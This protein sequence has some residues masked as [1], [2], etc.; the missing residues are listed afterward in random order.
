MQHNSN[1]HESLWE[2]D[3]KELW[4]LQV[5]EI[6]NNL[7]IPG[8][9]VGPACNSLSAMTA[10][11]RQALC[12]ISARHLGNMVDRLAATHIRKKNI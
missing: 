2:S 4:Q 9:A 10:A 8:S 6:N 11:I 5:Q 12:Q 7:A 1:T 3:E